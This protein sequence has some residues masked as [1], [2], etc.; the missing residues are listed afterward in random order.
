MFLRPAPVNRGQVLCKIVLLAQLDELNGPPGG[1]DNLALPSLAGSTEH[2][3]SIDLPREL[4]RW[5]A[6]P[7]LFGLAQ[8]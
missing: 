6:A 8:P 1:V 3:L 5:N 7:S 4:S 2:I